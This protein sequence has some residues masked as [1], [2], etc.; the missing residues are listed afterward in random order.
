MVKM[1]ISE[2]EELSHFERIYVCLAACKK[3]WKEECRPLINLDGCHIKW[4]HT[5]RLVVAVSIDA[6]NAMYPI[7]YI[8]VQYENE[9]TWKLFLIFLK[10]DLDIVNDSLLTSITDKQKGLIEEVKEVFTRSAHRFCVKYMCNNFKTQFK[11]LVLK[12]TLWSAAR[13]TIKHRLHK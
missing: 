7:A 6:K 8:A 12:Q 3:G 13:A 2:S 4:P 10:E 9:G 1:Q 5:G 11:G